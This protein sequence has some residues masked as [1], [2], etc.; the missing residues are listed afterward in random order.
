MYTFREANTDEFNALGAL[1]VEVY[2]QLEGFPS[3]E[4]QPSYYQKLQNIGAFTSCPKAK[5]FVAVSDEGIVDGGVV[6]F[7]DMQYYGAGGEATT[8]Q[9]AAAFR[10][11]AVNPRVRGKGLGRGLIQCCIEQAKKE[12][13]KSVVIHSTKTMMVAWK[14]YERMGFKRFTEIDFLQEG[15][16]VYGFRLL[17]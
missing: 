3:E 1:M 12:G 15:L 8:S 6:Y 14:M 16:S 13:H 7:G 2:A 11:L 5:L 9:D 4:E 17:L 10:L